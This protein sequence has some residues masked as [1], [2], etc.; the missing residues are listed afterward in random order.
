MPPCKAY[1]EPGTVAS[2]P[3][4]LARGFPVKTRTTAALLAFFLGG[5]GVH[6]FYLAEKGGVLRIILT[7]SIIGAPVSGVLALIDFVKLLTMD[8]AQFDS[9]YNGAS[10]TEEAPRTG[11]SNTW[12]IVAG[13]AIGVVV[14]FVGCM[15]IVVV[16][17]NDAVE[18]MESGDYTIPTFGVGIDESVKDNVGMMGPRPTDAEI[19]RA[20]QALRNAGWDYMSL[21][22][23]TDMRSMSIA[24]SITMFASGQELVKY[25]NSK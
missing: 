17:V 1:M 16:G 7:C 13:A 12:K 5:F 8:D 21:G 25:C 9:L 11:T 18:D 24:A 15:T 3:T 22:M 20:C 14:L 19:R 2:C 23:G 6:K 10:P 4:L